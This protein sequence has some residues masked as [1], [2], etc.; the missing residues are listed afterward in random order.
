LS[1]IDILS[2]E[3]VKSSI[4]QDLRYHSIDNQFE[5]ELVLNLAEEEFDFDRITYRMGLNPD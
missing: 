4:V 2:N 3:K 5:E 1:F